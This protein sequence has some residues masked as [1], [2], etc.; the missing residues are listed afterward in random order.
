MGNKVLP[1]LTIYSTISVFLKKFKNSIKSSERERVRVSAFVIYRITS[2]EFDG[3][4]SKLIVI[5][6]EVHNSNKHRGK[7]CY[8]II[9]KIII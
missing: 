3:L 6:L 4:A 2:H 1:S 8:V 7:R 5:F 9:V